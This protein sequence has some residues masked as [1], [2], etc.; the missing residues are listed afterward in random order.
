MVA[1]DLPGRLVII[2]GG[3][4]GTEC[5]FLF[6]GFGSDVVLVDSAE[7]PFPAAP[8]RVGEILAS[9]L[10]REGVD[11]RYGVGVSRV[12]DDA[13]GARVEFDD[14]TFV[15]ADRILVAV[16]RR[17]STS[18]LGLETLGL[19]PETPLPVGP[20]GRVAC[21]GSVWAMGD[22]CG[23]GQYTHL[24]NHQARVVADHLAGGGTRAFDDV[25]VPGC[26]FSSPP[27]V[28]VGPTWAELSDDDIVTADIELGSFPRAQT[29]ELD[30]GYLW[31][32]ARRSTGCLVA[33]TGIGP[34]FDELSHALVI[35]IDGRVP[36][37]R[38]RQSM[39][40]FPTVGEVVGPLFQDLHRQIDR[41]TPR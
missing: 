35:A 20:D 38:L 32:A 33:A 8:P 30:D 40:P 10:K 34:R 2:G 23:H 11:A 17:P 4:I 36:V 19:E 9:S 25:V 37:S 12:H 14:G 13:S 1:S 16:G 28:Q 6:A 27:I 41:V 3:V 18:G 26:V 24:A 7:R 5:A 39:Q 22:A 29:D 15:E 31:L 21:P